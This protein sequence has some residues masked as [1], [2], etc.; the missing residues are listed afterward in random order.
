M[1]YGVKLLVGDE[2]WRAILSRLVSRPCAAETLARLLFTLKKA[3]EDGRTERSVRSRRCQRHR[4]Y[5]PYT[6]AHQAAFQ[7]YTLSLEGT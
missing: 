6:K 3:I 1:K 4:V 2:T 5:L 7:L